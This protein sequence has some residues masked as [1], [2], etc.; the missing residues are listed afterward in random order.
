MFPTPSSLL[1]QIFFDQYAFLLTSLPPGPAYS[2]LSMLSLTLYLLAATVAP[3]LALNLTTYHSVPIAPTPLP[4]PY[5]AADADELFTLFSTLGRSTVWNLV[6]TLQLQG[7]SFEPEGMVRVGADRLFVSGTEHVVEPLAYGKDANGSSIIVNGTDRANGKGLGYIAVYDTNG[8]RIA[9]ATYNNITDLEYHLGGIDY[10]GQ[11]IWG[12]LA[13]YR[14][15]S[16]ATVL[17]IDPQ[18]LEATKVAHVTDHEGAIVHDTDTGK[19]YVM[20]WGGRNTSVLPDDGNKP[21]P[22]FTQPD[23]VV[24]NPSYFVDYQDCKF[25]GHPQGNGGRATAACSGV[26]T[27]G[28][29]ISSYNLGGITLVDLETMVPIAEIPITTRSALGTPLTQNPFDI[30]VVDGKLRVYFLP[31]QFDSTLYVY[32]AEPNSPYEYGGNGGMD[33][34]SSVWP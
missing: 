24:R 26:A 16:T 4:A 10:D 21:W 17:R 8:T 18:T 25:V 20:N 6:S 11:Y 15:N 28:S 31:D 32:E 14:P 5:A 2:S 12:T 3:A 9:L 30:A 19:L 22:Q 23:S 7:D 33:L 27:L 29:G 34:S 1:D 13:Q